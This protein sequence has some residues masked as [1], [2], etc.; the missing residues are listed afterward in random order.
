M[1]FP[2]TTLIRERRTINLFQEV[3]SNAKEWGGDV[4][5][6]YFK[7]PHQNNSNYQ[8]GMGAVGAVVSTVTELPDY[9]IAGV[10]D[11]KITSERSNTVRDVR[12]LVKDVVT[13]RPLKALSDIVRLPGSATRDAVVFAGGL[14]GSQNNYSQSA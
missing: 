13:L 6:R 1:I 12:E 3:G 8:R 9:L 14:H 7:T 10:V 4:G 5:N 2:R 11:K